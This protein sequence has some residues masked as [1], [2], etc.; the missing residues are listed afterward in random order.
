MAV[1]SLKIVANGWKQLEMAGNS[2]EIAGMGQKCLELKIGEMAENSWKCEEMAK[3][4]QEWLE[5]GLKLMEMV[6]HGWA[7]L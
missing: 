7:W 1:H 3:K 2:W 6:G 5:N 4:G